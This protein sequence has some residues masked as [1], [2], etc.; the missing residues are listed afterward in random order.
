MG[1]RRENTICRA[2]R[3]P[4]RH[5]FR[6]AAQDDADQPLSWYL[7][8]TRW[9]HGEGFPPRKLV[10]RAQRALRALGIGLYSEGG[11]S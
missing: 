5:S 6:F 4:R 11:K 10:A 8:K 3:V 9:L 7:K 2:P 1:N